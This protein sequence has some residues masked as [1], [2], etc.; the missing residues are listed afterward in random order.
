MHRSIGIPVVCETLDIV[1]DDISQPA[2]EK[3]HVYAAIEKTVPAPEVLEG[4]HGRGTGMRCH[5]TKAG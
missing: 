3:H 5:D 2:V 4:S 1:L